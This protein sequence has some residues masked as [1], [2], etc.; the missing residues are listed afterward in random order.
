MLFDLLKAILF[1]IVEGI[2]E[3]LPISSTGHLILLEEIL[4]LNVSDDPILNMQFRTM[5]EVVIQ[6]GAI[7]AVVVIY[8]NRL[9]PFERN[10]RPLWI[11]LILATLPAASIGFAADALCQATLGVDL[12]ALL[13]VPQ[14]VA[15]ALIIYGIAFIL[16]ELS[17]RNKKAEA[18]ELQITNKSALAIGFFQALAII[19]GTSRSGATI[20]GARL[21]GLD[22]KSSTEFSFFA[23][24]PAIL[25]A[26]FLKIIEFSQ[27]MISSKSTLSSQAYL[28]LTAAFFTAFAVSVPILK[29]LIS[30]LR[31][32]SFIP[33]GIYRILL[34]ITVF[35]TL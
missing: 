4:S 32:H 16:L 24:V 2:C 12:D 5:F 13:F 10:N 34:G 11:K 9:N 31:G 28:L 7:L 14:T 35:I 29:L 27:F 25:G 23:A 26:S 17:K 19:P 15:S 18:S 20:L 30:F 3:W 6:L 1:G 21:L 33:F 22:K 8:F